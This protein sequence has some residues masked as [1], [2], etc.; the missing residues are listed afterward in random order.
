MWHGHETWQTHS[1]WHT[2]IRHVTQ[3][4]EQRQVTFLKIDTDGHELHT[5]K[6]ARKW[7]ENGPG[8]KYAKV[9]FVPYALEKGNNGD[10]AAGGSYIATCEYM[11]VCVCIYIYDTYEKCSGRMCSVRRHAGQHRRPCRKWVLQI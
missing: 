1:S 10:P 11:Y 8:V 4:E 6:G 2:L 3:D 5:L 9:E 7:M